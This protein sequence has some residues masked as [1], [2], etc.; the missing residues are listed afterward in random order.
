[1]KKMYL[2]NE[3][4]YRKLTSAGV[5]FC[6]C[7][8]LIVELAI[9]FITGIKPLHVSVPVLLFLWLLSGIIVSGV[10]HA[11]A[12]LADLLEVPLTDIRDDGM[13]SACD[14]HSHSTITHLAA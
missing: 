13:I 3:K 4:T 1:M 8:G 7:M 6:A 14:M 10:L 9:F 5:I 11:V 2:K 12:A